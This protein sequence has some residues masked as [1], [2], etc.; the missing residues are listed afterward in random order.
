ML[1]TA[2]SQYDSSSQKGNTNSG[3]AFSHWQILRVFTDL[4]GLWELF[5]EK[6]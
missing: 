3:I 5:Q 4:E 1:L 2:N 6:R